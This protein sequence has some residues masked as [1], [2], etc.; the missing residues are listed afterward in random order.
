MRGGTGSPL[1]T[2]VAAKLTIVDMVAMA[3]YT[4]SLAP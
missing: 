3:A 1:M 2:A 4:A